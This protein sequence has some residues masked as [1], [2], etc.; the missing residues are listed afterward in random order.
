MTVRS[1]GITT[2]TGAVIGGLALLVAGP[3]LM[4]R[5]FAL[6]GDMV[7][8]PHQPWKDQWLGADGSVP[9]AVPGDAIV[10]ALTTV[11]PGDLLQK[12]VIVLLVAAAGWGM[13]H[14]LADAPPVARLGGAVVFAWNPYVYERL[15]I[16]HWALLCGYACLPWVAAAAIAVRRRGLSAAGLAVLVLPMAVAAWTSPTGGVLAAALAL[17]LVLPAV[18]AAGLVLAVAVLVNLPWLLPGVLNTTATGGTPGVAEFAARAD[19]PFGVVGSVLTLGGMWKVSVA[20]DLQPAW[21]FALL[22]LTIAAVGLLGVLLARRSRDGHPA[23]EPGLVV[24][25]VLGLALALL[26]TAGAG[27]SL[28]ESVVTAVPGAGILRDSQKWLAPLALLVAC[29]WARSME[30]ALRRVR[31]AGPDTPRWPIVVAALLTPVL[32]VPTLVWGLSGTFRPGVYPEEWSQVAA[33]MD[34]AGADEGRTVVLPWSAY[35]RF[36]WNH[37]HAVLDPAFRFFPGEVLTSDDLVI[38]ADTV[39][40]GESTLGASVAAVLA[41]GGDPAEGLRQ[42]GVGWVLLERRV[43]GASGAP[44]VSGTVLHDGAELMLVDLGGPHR[45]STGEHA[46][47]VRVVDGAVLLVTLLLICPAV[48]QTPFAAPL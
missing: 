48:V 40:E 31:A 8:V 6:V 1:R 26:P 21:L 32:A 43:P 23:G 47:L 16:G 38:D 11:V 24:I 9:R 13:L 41:A 15:A 19:T 45:T 36:T 4:A 10:S 46:V 44:G 42:L 7:F 30:S 33:K 27:R 18:R 22:S 17:A 25:A 35:R 28:L 39:V 14:L 29:G 20:P 5:G 3:L 34:E 2:A 37:G 12:A